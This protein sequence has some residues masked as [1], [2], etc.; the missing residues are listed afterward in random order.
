MIVRIKYFLILIQLI[1]IFPVS[2]GSL[3][4]VEITNTTSSSYESLTVLNPSDGNWIKMTGGDEAPIPGIEFIYNGIN[5]TNYTKGDKIINI[6][7][8][9]IPENQDYNVSYPF[10]GHP[11]YY[12]TDTVT[13]Q[14][15]GE[16]GLAGKTAYVYLIKTYPTQLKDALSSAVDGDTQPLR[17]LLSNHIQNITVTLDSNGDNTSIS[18]GILSPGDYVVVALLNRSND[19]NVTSSPQQHFR[20]LNTDRK[21]A[22]APQSPDHL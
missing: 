10:T 4:K 2:A 18:F 13:A 11:V 14:L 17:N 7:T 22:Q 12:S 21:S 20:F 6:T 15:L 3:V 1:L 8:F 5:S 19:Q 9:G 16:S